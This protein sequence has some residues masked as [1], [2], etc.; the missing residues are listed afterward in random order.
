LLGRDGVYL[1]GVESLAADR[2]GGRAA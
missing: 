1:A 2:A